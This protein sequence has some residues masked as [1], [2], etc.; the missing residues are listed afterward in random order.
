MF[1]QWNMFYFVDHTIYWKI[2]YKF[3]NQNTLSALVELNDIKWQPIYTTLNP[4]KQ[5]GWKINCK[6]RNFGGYFLRFTT[7]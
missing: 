1:L 3:P 4:I 6:N 5:S 2:D 7:L